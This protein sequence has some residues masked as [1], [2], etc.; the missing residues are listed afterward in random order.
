MLTLRRPHHPGRFVLTRRVFY[1]FRWVPG[2]DTLKIK[3]GKEILSE[4]ILGKE[5]HL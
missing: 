4:T 2:R 1:V 3:N 5:R